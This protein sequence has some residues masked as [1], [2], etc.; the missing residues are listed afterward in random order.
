MVTT[1]VLGLSDFEQPFQIDIDASAIAVGTVLSQASHPLAY[2][3]KKMTP[4]MQSAS[5]YVR[6][7]YAIT[8]AVKKWRQYLLGRKFLIYT[9]Q[10]SLWNLLHQTIQTPEQQKWLTK[11][12]GFDYEIHYKP[13]LANRVADALSRKSEESPSLLL[14]VSSP[15]PSLIV[16]LKRFYSQEAAGKA[17][18]DQWH[19]DSEFRGKF[20]LYDGLLYFGDR[21][22]VPPESELQ[23]RVLQELHSSPVGGHSGYRA[24]LA[25]V[26]SGFYWPLLAKMVKTFVSQCHICQQHKAVTRAPVGLL[27][28]LTFP[29]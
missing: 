5:T 12:L 23:Q 13:G 27:Q 10:Q 1:P 22:F 7:I 11:L 29:E 6:E 8:E 17:L 18:V 24:T 28:P 26:A 9:D 16:Q 20:K 21:L 2:F 14:A 4:K 19:S 25:R 3:S 15:V